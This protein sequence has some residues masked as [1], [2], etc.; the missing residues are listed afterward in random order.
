V[1]S[2]AICDSDLA[3]VSSS[4]VE[5]GAPITRTWITERE[6]W[7]KYAIGYRLARNIAGPQCL[8]INAFF[9][10]A[11]CDLHSGGE[12]MLVQGTRVLCRS[13]AEGLVHEFELVY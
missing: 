7:A 12:G 4:I 13:N 8:G 10:G 6:A 11:L 3:T 5:N 2:D 1:P 9:Q